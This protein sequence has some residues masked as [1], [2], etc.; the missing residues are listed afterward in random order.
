MKGPYIRGAAEAAA[1]YLAR[2]GY[3]VGK[4]IEEL[5]RNLRGS[6]AALLVALDH[7]PERLPSVLRRL[8]RSR[9]DRERLAA[10]AVLALFDSDWSRRELLAVL[11]ESSDQDATVECRTALY[12][13]TDPTAHQAVDRW[14]MQNPDDSEDFTT[15]QAMYRLAGGCDQV[16]RQGMLEFGPRVMPLRGVVPW[17]E[18]PPGLAS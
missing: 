7:A 13:S 4:L 8:L 2:H 11:E 1:L 17:E 15:A 6:Y 18:A 14:E 12:E 9:G 16:L 10:A 3:P 5:L